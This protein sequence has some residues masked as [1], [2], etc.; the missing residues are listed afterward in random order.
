MNSAAS[1]L[2]GQTLDKKSIRIFATDPNKWSWR[3]LA[4]DCVAFANSQGGWIMFGIEDNASAPPATQRI[5]ATLADR[6]RKGISQHTHN[7]AVTAELRTATNGGEFLV[8]HVL[9]NLKSVAATSDAR[10]FIRV[11]DESRRLY[12][13][14]IRCA[15]RPRRFLRCARRTTVSPSASGSAH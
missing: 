13:E 11:A 3:D 9:P 4:S 1:M 5:A 2:E 14:E 7:V 10:Y 15:R 8:L 6:L 12:P